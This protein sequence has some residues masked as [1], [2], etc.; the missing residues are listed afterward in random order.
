MQGPDG[1]QRTLPIV[2][3]ET[4]HQGRKRLHSFDPDEARALGV[5]L[6]GNA[7]LCAQALAQANGAGLAVAAPPPLVGLDGGRKG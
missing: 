4:T 5:A 1:K 7:A 2:V 3:L 6:I